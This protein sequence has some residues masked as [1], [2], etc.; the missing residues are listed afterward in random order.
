[1]RIIPTLAM[2]RWRSSVPYGL[3]L[4]SAGQER[5]GLERESTK[6]PG[7]APLTQHSV[8]SREGLNDHYPR[9]RQRHWQLTHQTSR[10]EESAVPPCRPQ[11][12]GDSRRDR[13]TRGRSHGQ[14]SDHSRR[15]G[16][17]RCASPRR[18]QVRPHTMAGRVAA[19]HEQHHRSLQT[20]A[21]KTHL[22]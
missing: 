7:D 22:L 10:G 5:L 12:E 6:G 16:L 1:M 17:E 9:S 4:F 8:R 3:P 19:D 15:R 11:S 18:S 14:R 2:S 21:S 20:R 13:N